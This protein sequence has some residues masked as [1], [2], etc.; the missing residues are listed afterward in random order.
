[1]MTADVDID[2]LPTIYPLLPPPHTHKS[3]P[4]II[5]KEIFLLSTSLYKIISNNY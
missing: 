5:D 4:D 2:L 1:M 3:T